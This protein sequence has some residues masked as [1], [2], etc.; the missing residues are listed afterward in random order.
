M[1][2][3]RLSAPIVLRLLC[4]WLVIFLFFAIVNMEVFGLT[5]WSSG[6]THNINFRSLSKALVMLAFMSTG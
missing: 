2:C 4:L 5:R 1:V 3:A 6:E